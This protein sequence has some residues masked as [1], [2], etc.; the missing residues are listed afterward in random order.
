MKKGYILVAT[1]LVSFGSFSATTVVKNP[2]E[3]EIKVGVSLTVSVKSDGEPVK[4]ALVKIV[5]NRMVI[6]AGTSDD[7]GNTKIS[8]ESY[9]DQLVTIEVF[10]SMY[11]S[12]KLRDVVLTEGK[13]FNVTMVSKTESAEDVKA[14]SDE[15]VAKTQE[16]LEKEKQATQEA[17]ERKE[18]ALKKQE[19]AKKETEEAKKETEEAK[20]EAEEAKKEAE[21]LRNGGESMTDERRK[22]IESDILA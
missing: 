22:Q 1:M 16:Q 9:G 12:T 3:N 10:H 11:K 2:M 19:E 7:S 5:S 18:E 14:E 20:K 21:E 17:I 4:G 6:G 15:K 13:T 8:I